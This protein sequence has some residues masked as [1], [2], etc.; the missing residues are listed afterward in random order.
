MS[1]I[2]P[3][4]TAFLFQVL[5]I[6]QNTL[7]LLVTKYPNIVLLQRVAILISIKITWKQTGFLIRAWK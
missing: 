4:I 6:F 2:T 5:Q 3:T 7:L 1:T